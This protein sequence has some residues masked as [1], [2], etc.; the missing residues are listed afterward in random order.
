MVNECSALFSSSSLSL[1]P[2][3][4]FAVC[5]VLTSIAASSALA[6]NLPSLRLK[7]RSFSVVG[8]GW[9]A[10]L[11]A[12]PSLPSSAALPNSRESAPATPWVERTFCRTSAGMPFR[13]TVLSLLSARCTAASTLRALRAKLSLV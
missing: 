7:S 12:L 1:S 9:T 5:A 10:A 4:S 13:M 3:L 2:T 11:R 8:N 6:G